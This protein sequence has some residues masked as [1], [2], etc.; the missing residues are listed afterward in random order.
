M[1][2]NDHRMTLKKNAASPRMR[3][4][5]CCYM[6]RYL[7]LNLNVFGKLLLLGANDKRVVT[8]GQRV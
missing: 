4:G 2:I 6:K 8:G 3:T 7:V 1:T 5:C